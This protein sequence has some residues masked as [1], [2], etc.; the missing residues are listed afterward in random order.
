MTT[1]ALHTTITTALDAL[2]DALDRGHSDT[3]TTFLLAMSRF[4]RYSVSNQFLIASQRPDA[5]LV[6]GFH[7]WKGLRRVVRKGEHGIAILAPITR[8]REDASVDDTTSIVG[9]RLA[10]V[11]DVSQ[12][13]GEPLPETASPVGDPGGALDRLRAAI[14]ADGIEVTDVDALGGALGVSRGG[15][16]DVL[17]T[18]DPATAFVVLAHEYAH[19]RLHH[20]TDRPEARNVRELEAQAVAFVVSTAS[21]VDALAMSA[22]YLHLYRGDRSAL[23]ASLQRIQRTATAILQRMAVTP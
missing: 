20:G 16:I 7:A 8:T 4:H 9:F 13:D 3:L 10:H 5:T 18:L 23:A 6:A 11:F 19:E 17:R 12:T 22:D 1:D 2:G 14:H 21:G 15:R